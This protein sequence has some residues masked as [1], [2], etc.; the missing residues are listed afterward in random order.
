MSNNL[1]T[2]SA[3][4]RALWGDEPIRPVL[5]WTNPGK[6]SHWLRPGEADRKWEKRNV[7][8]AVALPPE[9]KDMR[10]D[11]RV[12]AD[13]AAAI[14]GLWVD[15]DNEDEHAHRK[16]NLPSFVEAR[17]FVQGVDPPPTITVRSGHGYQLWWLFK[18]GP[19]VFKSDTER[20][21]AERLCEHWQS[22]LRRRLG[23]ALDSTWDLA[24]VMRLPG[25]TNFKGETPVEVLIDKSDGPRLAVEDW[26]DLAK[27][28]PV[29][30][31][32]PKKAPP[33]A[34]APLSDGPE[35]HSGGSGRLFIRADVTPDA[36]WLDGLREI[37]KIR[38]TLDE[39]R[40]FESPSE[41]DQSLASHLAR[42]PDTSDQQIIDVC[43][44]HRRVKHKM[45]P[46]RLDYYTEHTIK[47]AR[48][49]AEDYDDDT[50]AM[51][52]EDMDIVK[53]LQVCDGDGTPPR[54]RFVTPSGSM[55]LPD[56]SHIL[57]QRKFRIAV[58]NT[59]KVALRSMKNENWEPFVQRKLTPKIETTHPGDPDYPQLGAR[60]ETFEW[61][62][63]YLD[64]R[65]TEVEGGDDVTDAP[66]V[67]NGVEHIMPAHFNEWLK[68]NRNETFTNHGLHLRL[69]DVGWHSK[70]VRIPKGPTVN[71]WVL[72]ASRARTQT[73]GHPLEGTPEHA[74]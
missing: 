8:T 18:G 10:D 71:R 5:I 72:D 47:K 20:E 16:A 64:S 59:F 32:T 67:L 53:I 58:L 54:Y 60:D 55:T 9:N 25:T 29:Q 52:A 45:P 63:D 51:A 26:R 74:E 22:E 19:W 68:T 6:K 7:Y 2:P 21:E 70:K 38:D 56:G 36:E 73:C 1:N 28:W 48:Q 13:E 14:A 49:S 30:A 66:F 4:L 62:A 69:S 24:R 65:M 11:R 57:E 42:I 61:I 46:K 33:A 50:P 43:V 41:C 44:Y 17:D 37:D 35:P 34:K 3:F 23:K 12:E 27:T 31:K 39:R 15:V 40:G